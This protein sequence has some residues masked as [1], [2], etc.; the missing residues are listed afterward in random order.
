WQTTVLE[1]EQP[2]TAIHGSLALIGA[3]PDE[4]T[5]L[6]VLEKMSLL[7]QG[8]LSDADFVDLLRVTQVALERGQV[9]PS[10][11]LPLRHQ[12][13][14]EF[15]TGDPRMNREL[16]RLAAYLRAD[17]IA[18]RALEFIAGDAPQGDRIQVAMYL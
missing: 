14:E 6:L 9:D 1:S 7:M 16:V 18:P 5:A 13:A 11:V 17:S 12:I 2:R 4:A 8:F 10:R 3:S 15:P